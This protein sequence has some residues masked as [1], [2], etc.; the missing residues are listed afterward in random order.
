M[1]LNPL[2][3][4]IEQ[5]AQQ[6]AKDRRGKKLTKHIKLT[7]QNS[8]HFYLFC[9]LRGCFA[10]A[11]RKTRALE[12]FTAILE[13]ANGDIEVWMS[14]ATLAKRLGRTPKTVR[15]ALRAL[16]EK[17]ILSLLDASTVEISLHGKPISKN[18]GYVIRIHTPMFW[19][20]DSIGGVPRRMVKYLADYDSEGVDNSETPVTVTGAPR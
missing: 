10:K 4:A 16:V 2:Q 1:R 7:R 5:T 12:T 3:V 9:F 8:D 19:D 20:W 6:C 18:Q 13:Q 17:N 15:K 14:I 11:L